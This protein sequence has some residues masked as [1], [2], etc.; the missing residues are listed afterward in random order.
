MFE[1]VFAKRRFL[2]TVCMCMHIYMSAFIKLEDSPLHIAVN[3]GCVD[4][5]KYLVER[6]ADANAQDKVCMHTHFV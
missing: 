5:V 3:G 2:Y 1:Y 6:G 4:V